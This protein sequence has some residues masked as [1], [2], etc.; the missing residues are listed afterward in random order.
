MRHPEWPFLP[1][2][3]AEQESEYGAVSVGGP[4]QLTQKAG[5]LLFVPRH[6]SH[7]VYTF[8]CRSLVELIFIPFQVLNLAESVGFAVEVQDYMY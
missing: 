8:V 2:S 4:C 6:W 1:D 3:S 5:E 7:Q